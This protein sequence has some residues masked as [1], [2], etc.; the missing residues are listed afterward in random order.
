MKS[1]A[2]LA[3][4]A[5]AF[6]LSGCG[7][8]QADKAE[9]DTMDER[10]GGKT[11]ADPALTQA[12]EDQIMVDPTLSQQSNEHSVRPPDTP[13]QA[14]IPPDVLADAAN[15]NP[16]ETLG[17]RAAEQAGAAKARFVGCQLDVAYSVQFSNR[18]PADLPLYPKAQVQEAAGSDTPGCQLRAVTFT[19][20]AAPR[21]LADYY[22]ILGKRAGYDAHIGTVTDGTMV[23]GVRAGDGAAF[24]VTL[25]PAGSGTSADLVSNRG[26]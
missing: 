17:A 16:S 25:Q 12:L 7:G 11:G 8:G 20:A 1:T 3:A 13:L 9:L 4:L 19:A 22:L 18:L 14:P 6:A 26:R 24:Y 23:S 5:F 15:A 2:S 10:L 21:A